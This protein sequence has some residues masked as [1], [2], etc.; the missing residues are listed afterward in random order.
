MIT[1]SGRDDT[2]TLLARVG[3]E[4]GGS[5]QRLVDADAF[6]G[7]IETIVSDGDDELPFRCAESLDIDSYGALGLAFKT[8]A[9]SCSSW[10][11]IFIGYAGY[12]SLRLV[13]ADPTLPVFSS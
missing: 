1:A 2:S 5:D 13:P 12:L 4:V 11:K 7:V 3:L 6:Y 10:S 8:S 9:P